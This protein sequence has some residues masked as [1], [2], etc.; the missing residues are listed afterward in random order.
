MHIAYPVELQSE[1]LRH[2]LII[3]Q[4]SKFVMDNT[5]TDFNTLTWPGESLEV[6][7]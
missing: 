4:L 2:T 7:T 5:L 3:P 6:E 1:T